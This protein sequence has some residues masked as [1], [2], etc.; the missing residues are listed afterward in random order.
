MYNRNIVYNSVNNYVLDTDEIK[1]MPD[2]ECIFVCCLIMCYNLIFIG[3]MIPLIK[4]EDLNLN[5]TIF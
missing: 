5:S 3:I 2:K 4:N 1:K